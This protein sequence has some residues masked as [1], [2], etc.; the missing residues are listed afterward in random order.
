MEKSLVQEVWRRAGNACEYCRMPQAFYGTRHQIDHVIA[1]QHK[2]PTTLDNLALA[3]F[4]CNN[5]KGPNLS[6]VDPLTGKVV[7]LFNPRRDRWARH[8]AWDGPRLLGKTARGRA[9]IE[10]L[11]I[12]HPDYVA[13][14]EALIAEGVFPPRR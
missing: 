13:V 7:R 8:F 10:L 5:H 3:C 4:P 11:A 6:S 12:N 9:T 1:E 14:R 2:G